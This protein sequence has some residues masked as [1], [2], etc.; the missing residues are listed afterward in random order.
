[1]SMDNVD[2][3]SPTKP[4]RVDP[5]KMV[6]SVQRTN[7]SVLIAYA[8]REMVH[9]AFNLETSK[10]QSNWNNVIGSGSLTERSRVGARKIKRLL[11]YAREEVSYERPTETS[12]LD[13]EDENVKNLLLELFSSDPRITA[14]P[15]DDRLQQIFYNLASDLHGEWEVKPHLEANPG[16][17]GRSGR[18][19]QM[20]LYFTRKELAKA[21]EFFLIEPRL[22]PDLP[23]QEPGEFDVASPIRNLT[24]PP[25]TPEPYQAPL[26]IE[27]AYTF[28]PMA[29]LCEDT[30][31]AKYNY[32]NLSHAEASLERSVAFNRLVVV[33]NQFEEQ[34]KQL[35]SGFARIGLLGDRIDLNN[36][37]FTLAKNLPIDQRTW[38]FLT[39]LAC[40]R[41][42][43]TGRMKLPRTFHVAIRSELKLVLEEFGLI[44][45]EQTD[46]SPT[47][48]SSFKA[49]ERSLQ[50]TFS[51]LL[52]NNVRLTPKPAPNSDK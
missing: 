12:S 13:F 7:A 51:F 43:F 2:A 23:D 17:Y 9:P 4:D 36:L 15:Q 42:E 48:Q 49:Q 24:E 18:I 29:S 35:T 27:G 21:I 14:Q 10:I 31:L 25:K 39:D 47:D 45:P 19:L 40:M 11:D 44:P 38:D 33:G 6:D 1:M 28:K 20:E 34:L 52:E 37:N 5:F 41:V 46:E 26:E 3:R 32:P 30:Y 16:S 22:L 50:E 8:Y